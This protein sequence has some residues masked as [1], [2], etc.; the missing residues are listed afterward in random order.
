[1]KNISEFT[2]LWMITI[3]NYMSIK[4]NL[5]SAS[6]MKANQQIDAVILIVYSL[7]FYICEYI[8]I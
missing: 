3:S 8:K 4:G 2:L 1:M 5:S 7:M 6:F